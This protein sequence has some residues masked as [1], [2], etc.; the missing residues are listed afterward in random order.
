[1][2]KL[3]LFIFVASLAICFSSCSNDDDDNNEQ[4]FKTTINLYVGDSV[5]LD[6]NYVSDNSFV[7][8]LNGRYLRAEHVGYTTVQNNKAI[9]DVY[10]I[11]KNNKFIDPIIEWGKTSEYIKTKCSSYKI[12]SDSYEDGLRNITYCNVSPYTFINYVFKNNSLK[13]VYVYCPYSY[14]DSYA[15]YLKERFAFISKLSGNLNYTG[16]DGYTLDKIK[17]YVTMVLNVSTI[18]TIYRDKNYKQ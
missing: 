10:I 1:M 9:R 5:K 2:K 7:A 18:I 6:G 4:V 8:S 14:L 3:F 11:G 17:T 12:L 15:E 13:M 16:V